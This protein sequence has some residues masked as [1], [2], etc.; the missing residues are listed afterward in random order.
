MDKFRK[1][2]DKQDHLCLRVFLKKQ[3]QI[4]QKT[5]ENIYIFY[6]CVC[7]SVHIQKQKQ[8]QYS[9]IKNPFYKDTTVHDQ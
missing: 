8:Y 2:K 7:V 4:K 6:V 1:V 5:A 3:K 9:S